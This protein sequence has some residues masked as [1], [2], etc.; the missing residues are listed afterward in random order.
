VEAARS[1]QV[2]EVLE[3]TWNDDELS[4]SEEAAIDELDCLLL[5]HFPEECWVWW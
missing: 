2:L 5:E 1:A 4:A 3:M